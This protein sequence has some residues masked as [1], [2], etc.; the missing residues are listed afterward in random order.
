V[1]LFL[2]RGWQDNLPLP[3][4]MPPWVM[5]TRWFAKTY[6]WDV[7]VVK[8]QPLEVLLWYPVIEEAEAAATAQLQRQE[9]RAQGPRRG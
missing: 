4:G 1:A 2:S 6:G 8:R 7:D 5:I 9:Q 3:D